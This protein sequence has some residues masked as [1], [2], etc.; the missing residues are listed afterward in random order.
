MAQIVPEGAEIM[1]IS[2]SPIPTFTPSKPQAQKAGTAEKTFP[3]QDAFH[4]RLQ[5]IQEN[6]D[7]RVAL[8]ERQASK[9]I[10]A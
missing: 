10:I 3:G 6:R 4:Q 7:L 9:G 1:Q 2:N 5:D 8:A